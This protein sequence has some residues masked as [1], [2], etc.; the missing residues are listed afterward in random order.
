MTTRKMT[1][2]QEWQ[3]VTNGADSVLIQVM[4]G[5]V[6]LC[7]SPAR[8]EAGAPAHIFYD[9]VQISPPTRAWIRTGLG[10]DAVVIVS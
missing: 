5:V 10:G 2:T 8:P 4:S 9:L 1:L 6:Y 7:D 3:Q